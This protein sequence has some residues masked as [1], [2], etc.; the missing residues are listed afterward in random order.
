MQHQPNAPLNPRSPLVLDA[1]DL[2]RRPGS[3]RVAERTVPAPEGLGHELVG[4]PAG[5][6][7]TLS[8]RLESVSEGVLVC[9]TVTGLLAGGGGAGRRPRRRTG[10]RPAP[11]GEAYAPT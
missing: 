6:E 4:V 9:G 11:A 8:L 5:A 7:L 2:P 1:G 3:M 10:D